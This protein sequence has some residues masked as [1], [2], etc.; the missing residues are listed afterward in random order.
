M[1]G[2]LDFLCIVVLMVFAAH[3]WQAYFEDS[4]SGTAI[5]ATLAWAT[6]MILLLVK[7]LTN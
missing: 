6:S 2:V 5:L 4:N 3:Y 7:A 1:I